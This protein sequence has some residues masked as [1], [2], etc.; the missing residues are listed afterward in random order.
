MKTKK[1]AKIKVQTKYQYISECCGKPAHKPPVERSSADFKENKY[2]ECGLG[3]WTCGQCEQSC[4][5]KRIKQ[6]E[7]SGTTGAEIRT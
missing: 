5:V 4:K 7:Q 6:Q 1:Q 2:S 3:H